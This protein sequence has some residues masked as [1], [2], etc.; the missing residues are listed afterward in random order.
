M[1]ISHPDV[2]ATVD[3]PPTVFEVVSAYGTVGL[4]LGIPTVGPHNTLDF[5]VSLI[6]RFQANYSLCGAFHPLSK[7]IICLVMLRGRHRG[8]PVAIDR[9]VMLPELKLDNEM[10]LQRRM[11]LNTN[12]ATTEWSPHGEDGLSLRPA[13]TI[14]TSN[15]REAAQRD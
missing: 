2:A 6:R 15:T 14:Q 1:G 8:L 12:P 5:R 7:L 4:S 9:A 3:T 11:S 10:T 13:P